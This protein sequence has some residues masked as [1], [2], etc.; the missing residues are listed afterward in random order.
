[1]YTLRENIINRNDSKSQLYNLFNVDINIPLESILHRRSDINIIKALLDNQNIE[2]VLIAG[3]Y[4]SYKK[5]WTLA[6]GDIDVFIYL[7]SLSYLQ[8]LRGSSTITVA[9]ITFSKVND[10]DSRFQTYTAPEKTELQLIFKYSRLSDKAL[11]LKD[12]DCFDLNICK[13]GYDCNRQ[14]LIYWNGQIWNPNLYQHK[15]YLQS[16]RLY[17]RYQK[18]QSRLNLNS[19][20]NMVPRLTSLCKIIIENNKKF[21]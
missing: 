5:Q 7:N 1:M 4:M 6:Y 14:N 20:L 16:G 19:N 15:H 17:Q 11:L 10:Y 3:G 21:F 12:L 13:V 18:Y 2:E 8:H 9:G